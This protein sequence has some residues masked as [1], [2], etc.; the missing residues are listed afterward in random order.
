MKTIEKILRFMYRCFADAL[1]RVFN[2]LP[3]VI[4]EKIQ[5]EVQ[6]IV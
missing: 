3:S 4:K 5:D 6:E 1:V 2:E